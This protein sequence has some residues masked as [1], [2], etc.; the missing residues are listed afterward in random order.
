[1]S[2]SWDEATM[3]FCLAPVPSG[4]DPIAT[5]SADK[6]NK[7]VVNRGGKDLAKIQSIAKAI[8]GSEAVYLFVSEG[9]QR[10]LRAFCGDV[11]LTANAG[12]FHVAIHKPSRDFRM[13]YVMDGNGGEQSLKVVVEGPDLTLDLHA[14]G[15]NCDALYGTLPYLLGFGASKPS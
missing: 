8:F 9:E 5:E 4:T 14:T 1:M 7:H 10:K 11:V 3:A 15:D 2:L 6:Q 13:V 12:E